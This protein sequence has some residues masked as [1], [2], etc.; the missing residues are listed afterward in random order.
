MNSLGKQITLLKYTWEYS[1]QICLASY[2][3]S[4]TTIFII[5]FLILDKDQRGAIELIE[6]VQ[7]EL[8]RLYVKAS[9]EILTAD[10]KYNK[11]RQPC[12]TKRSNLIAKI[13][14]FWDTAVSFFSKAI[15]LKVVSYLLIFRLRCKILPIVFWEFYSRCTINVH[16]YYSVYEKLQATRAKVA[17]VNLI[18]GSHFSA[19][20]AT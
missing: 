14:N 16:T 13:P 15:L 2:I 9:E 19:T 4:H 8:D 11:L 6:E 3:W 18:Y 20:E 7:N 5:I 12:F 1:A 10:Q 17:P